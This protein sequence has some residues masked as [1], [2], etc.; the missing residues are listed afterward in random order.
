MKYSKEHQKSFA[1]LLDEFKQFRQELAAKVRRSFVRYVFFS[2]VA[3]PH[4]ACTS[5]QSVWLFGVT[6]TGATG[7]VREVGGQ[8]GARVRDPIG[9]LNAALG[10]VADAFR[11][12]QRRGL[13]ARRVLLY[14]VS[15]HGDG[16][17]DFPLHSVHALDSGHDLACCPPGYA[18]DVQ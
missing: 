13:R 18:P 12:A 15:R 2:S 11:C 9:A 3:C 14:A 8:S 7:G 10:H 4:F 5:V 1:E 6:C 16:G 17:G